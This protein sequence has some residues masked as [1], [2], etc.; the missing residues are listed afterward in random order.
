MFNQVMHPH[1]KGLMEDGV[2][3]IKKTSCISGKSLA[4]PLKCQSLH[5]PGCSL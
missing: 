3:L 2:R 4:T 5:E 1:E